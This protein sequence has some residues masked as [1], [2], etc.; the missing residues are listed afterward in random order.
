MSVEPQPTAPQPATHFQAGCGLCLLV[1]ILLAIV[2]GP[3]L[4]DQNAPLGWEFD[5][6]AVS[7][8]G[9]MESVSHR[10]AQRG[11]ELI[12]TTRTT[13]RNDKESWE[14]TFKRRRALFH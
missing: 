13:D 7:R 8:P 3:F 14:M 12:A 2:L 10:R 1:I 11:W 5:K 9:D 4:I 6:E